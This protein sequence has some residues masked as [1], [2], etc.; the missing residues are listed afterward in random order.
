MTKIQRLI[1]AAIA[2]FGSEKKLAD[3]VGV[4]QP[5]INEAKRTGRVGP[6]LAIGLERAT[7]GEIKRSDLRP[8]LWEKKPPE[9]LQ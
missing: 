1:L 8:D 9:W 7:R 4:T 5:A 3:A 2:K 6:R